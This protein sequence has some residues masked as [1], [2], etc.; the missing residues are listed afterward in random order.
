MLLSEAGVC[1]FSHLYSCLLGA[2]IKIAAGS[3]LS[4]R[5]KAPPARCVLLQR[6]GVA[7]G[8]QSPDPNSR[9]RLA[10][11]RGGRLQAPHRDLFDTRATNRPLSSP[12]LAEF[13]GQQVWL[14][15]L[16]PY[17]ILFF[18]SEPF[19]LQIEPV[20]LGLPVP[21]FNIPNNFEAANGGQETGHEICLPISTLSGPSVT[22]DLQQG[23]LGTNHR[24]LAAGQL[25]ERPYFF[26][27]KG[28]Q[29]HPCSVGNRPVTPLTTPSDAG[30]YKDVSNNTAEKQHLRDIAPGTCQLAPCCSSQREPRCAEASVQRYLGHVTL[31]LCDKCCWPISLIK[32]HRP[33]STVSHGHVL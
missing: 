2:T 22:S 26:L 33:S 29:Q 16:G 13:L 14:A 15:L 6:P 23:F 1:F 32:T 12:D 20:K 27:N 17:F 11:S 24:A 4:L 5:E 8:K 31:K 25:R 28:G 21:V 10:V 30:G 7:H 9:A 18:F 19:T 3:V